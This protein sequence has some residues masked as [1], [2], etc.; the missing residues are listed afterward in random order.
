MN[1]DMIKKVAGTYLRAVAASVLALYI[2][3]ITDPK[4]LL[5]AAIAGLI[6]PIAKALNPKDYDYGYKLK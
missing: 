3:G 2:S 5:N 4:V 1:S 6:G